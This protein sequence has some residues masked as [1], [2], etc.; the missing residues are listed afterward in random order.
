MTGNSAASEETEVSIVLV[1]SHCLLNGVFRDLTAS[2]LLTCGSAAMAQ[3]HECLVVTC[4]C[5]EGGTAGYVP[6]ADL[7]HKLIRDET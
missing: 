2:V 3:T 5:H 6:S 7:K 1:M 4:K